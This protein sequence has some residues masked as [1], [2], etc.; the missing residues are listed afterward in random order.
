MTN[1]PHDVDTPTPSHFA[2]GADSVAESCLSHNHTITSAN[3]ALP[4]Q[5][6]GVDRCLELRESVDSNS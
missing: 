5:E 6:S 1:E 4:G 3:I 2:S